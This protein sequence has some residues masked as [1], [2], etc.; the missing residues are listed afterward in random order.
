MRAVRHAKGKQLLFRQRHARKPVQRLR[1]VKPELSVVI[2]DRQFPAVTHEINI[3][4]R[5][6]G[7]HP[8]APPIVLPAD[9]QQLRNLVKEFQRAFKEADRRLAESRERLDNRYEAVRDLL[10]QPDE[11]GCENAMKPKL[12]ALSQEAL[13]QGAT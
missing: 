5:R 9:D 10:T 12:L 1:K 7:G 8:E 11:P 4:P 13:I 2:L 6:L 3:P